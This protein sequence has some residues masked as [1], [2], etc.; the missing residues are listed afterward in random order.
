MGVRQLRWVMR[1]FYPIAM[2]YL[3]PGM[4]QRSAVDADLRGRCPGPTCAWGI[5]SPA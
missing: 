4:L 2:R 5:A 1:R 3:V